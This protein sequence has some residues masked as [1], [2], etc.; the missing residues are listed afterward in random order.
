[1]AAHKAESPWGR[2]Q[3]AWPGEQLR[4]PERLLAEQQQ[5]PAGCGHH[6]LVP[7]EAGGLHLL[8]H[9]GC[10]LHPPLPPLLHL[11]LLPHLAAVQLRHPVNNNNHK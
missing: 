7:P 6:Q 1:M 9:P 10:Q 11:R 2:D 3:T 5:P 4:D 8:P